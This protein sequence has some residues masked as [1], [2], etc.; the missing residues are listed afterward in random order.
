MTSEN[1]LH[2]CILAFC[3]LSVVNAQ[4]VEVGSNSVLM[5]GQ[6]SARQTIAIWIMWML[7]KSKDNGVV[8]IYTEAVCLKKGCDALT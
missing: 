8:R 6:R 5:R 2:W 1:R 7:C 4:E 3:H